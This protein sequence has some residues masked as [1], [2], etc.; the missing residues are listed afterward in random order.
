MFSFPY[1]FLLG[2]PQP[3]RR[4]AFRHRGGVGRGRFVSYTY[5]LFR[6]PEFPLLNHFNFVIVVHVRHSQMNL[7]LLSLNHNF[8]T[9]HDVDTLLHL[10]YAATSE[11]VDNHS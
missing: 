9:V 5:F 10:L 4:G 1:C 2:P 11:L 6:G 8:F 3:S 7:P